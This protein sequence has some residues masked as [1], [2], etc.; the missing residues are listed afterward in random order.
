M[1]SR[2]FG[3]ALPFVTV[4][5]VLA[6]ASGDTA[7]QTADGQP[8]AP[9][10]QLAGC[11]EEPA[12][13]H[14][15]AREKAKTFRPPR[16]PDGAPDFSGIWDR[17]RVTAHNI[18]EHLA[19]FGDPGGRSFVVDPVDGKIPYQ[20]WADAQ[21]KTHFTTYIDPQALCLLPGAG[22]MAYPVG[23]YQIL[24][25][26]GYVSFFSEHTH[27]YRI[28]PID[29]RPHI[30]AAISLASGDSVGRWDGNTLVVDVTN[31]NGRSWFDD[32]GNF[33]SSGMHA[34]ER[35]TMIDVDAIH[36]EVTFEDP[37]V[38]TRPWTIALGVRRNKQ[39]GFELLESA[40]LEGNRNIIED[41]R[42]Q[43]L[44]PF[45]GITPPE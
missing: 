43:G 16:T 13:F 40:C 29:G 8:W 32:A 27:A 39:P 44:K 10:G 11:S 18:E 45:L 30:G 5:G 15:C 25:T 37:K 20:P 38:Y 17:A 23:G 3:N 34:V 22:R 6:F 4:L 7:G 33:S 28:I 12:R 31:L 24:Q 26:P 19:S 35:W 36:Y 14:A 42:R 41:L 9:Y 21:R 1:T 2:T